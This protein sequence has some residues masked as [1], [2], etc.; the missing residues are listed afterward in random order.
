MF[1]LLLAE[2]LAVGALAAAVACASGPEV[3]DYG[4]GPRCAECPLVAVTRVLDGDTLDTS[5]GRVRPVRRRRS[6][7]RGRVRAIGY[8]ES[9]GHGRAG[10][11]ARARASPSRRVRPAA[12]VRLS[13]GRA[14]HR[15]GVGLGRVRRRL[16][17]GW[18]AQGG[19]GG[20][21]A[22][23][24]VGGQGMFMVIEQAA[25]RG[26]LLSSQCVRS[27]RSDPVQG[28]PEAL[29]TNRRRAVAR[30]RDGRSAGAPRGY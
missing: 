9:E 2:L 22:R 4:G 10:G 19:V 15:R 24:A 28:Y 29:S 30:T 21:G 27:N 26:G 6:G 11:Q 25:A 7:S 13:E 20:V 18:S 3:D 8:G 23:R 14:E 12:G 1:R 17:G 16:A 5:A